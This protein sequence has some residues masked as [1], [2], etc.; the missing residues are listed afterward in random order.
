MDD[1]EEIAASAR[2]IQHSERR[3]LIVQRVELAFRARRGDALAPW[4]D[5]RRDDDAQDVLL[6]RVVGAPAMALC[7][8]HS[9]EAQGAEGRRVDGGYLLHGR[10]DTWARRAL[11][12]LLI[13]LDSP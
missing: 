11:Q 13:G 10:D 5:D 4:S 12:P 2:R 9:R 7:A 1:I 3:E 8:A 6:A